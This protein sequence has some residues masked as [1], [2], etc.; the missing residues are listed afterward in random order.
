MTTFHHVK[1][2]V[3]VR[4]VKAARVWRPDIV[5]RYRRVLEVKTVVADRSALASIYANQDDGGPVY[6]TLHWHTP[7]SS[8]VAAHYRDI[9]LDDA[10]K[11][12]KG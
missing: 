5:R 10:I 2:D 7:L 3:K 9:I 1:S 8:L 4:V 12:L 6:L 11:F